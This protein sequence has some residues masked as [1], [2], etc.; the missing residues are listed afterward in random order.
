MAHQSD[1]FSTA[2]RATVFH[3]PSLHPLADEPPWNE[4]SPSTEGEDEELSPPFIPHSSRDFASSDEEAVGQTTSIVSLQQYPTLYDFASSDSDE[5]LTEECLT[6]DLEASAVKADSTCNF[7]GYLQE[8]GQSAE[9]TDLHSDERFSNP[10]KYFQDLERL[11][12]SVFDRSAV[13]FY[14]SV[15]LF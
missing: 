4:P 9:Y 1:P 7:D 10:R 14:A 8:G 5:D 13:R 15:K 12:A 11:E 6:P 3:W 2:S